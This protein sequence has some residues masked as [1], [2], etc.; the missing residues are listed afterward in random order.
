MHMHTASI[1]SLISGLDSARVRTGEAGGGSWNAANRDGCFDGDGGGRRSWRL[2]LDILMAG[3]WARVLGRGGPEVPFATD[4]FS[5]R[6]RRSLNAG[7]R[8]ESSPPPG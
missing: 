1:D 3:L 5:K 8:G 7:I 6:L 2:S 4:R